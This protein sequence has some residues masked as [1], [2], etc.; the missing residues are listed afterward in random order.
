[1]TDIGG[2]AES[3]VIDRDMHLQSMPC[4][5]RDSDPIAVLRWACERIKTMTD[6][7][8]RRV[9]M[10][11]AVIPR[12][13]ETYRQ[14]IE[15]AESMLGIGQ[16]PQ[17]K[18]PNGWPWHKRKGRPSKE[19]RRLRNGLPGWRSIVERL[20]ADAV[21]AMK[22]I[23]LVQ[24]QALTRHAPRIDIHPSAWEQFAAMKPTRTSTGKRAQRRMSKPWAG[25]K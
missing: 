2:I 21:E 13:I 25:R 16:E 19:E 6:H 24:L 22:P 17:G 1:M 23:E 10:S 3:Q 5:E 7:P 14:R 8:P 12:I 9:I 18:F 15:E 20:T 11:A 4:R